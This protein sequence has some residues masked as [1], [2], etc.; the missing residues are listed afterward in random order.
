MSRR[1]YHP[2]LIQFTVTFGFVIL[3]KSIMLHELGQE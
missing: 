1:F 2:L 3:Y